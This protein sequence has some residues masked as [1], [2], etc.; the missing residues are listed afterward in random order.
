MLTLEYNVEAIHGTKR[1]HSFRARYAK[2]MQRCVILLVG[3]AA[4]GCASEKPVVSFTQQ[5]KDLGSVLEQTST[6]FYLELA[7]C[8][9]GDV[10]V[11]RLITTC[12]CTTSQSE[13]PFLLKAGASKKLEA[14]FDA[15]KVSGFKDVGILAEYSAKQEP[16][17]IDVL[18]FIARATV[19]AEI[20]AEVLVAPLSIIFPMVVQDPMS[21][22]VNLRFPAGSEYRVIDAAVSNPAFQARVVD[23]ATSDDSVTILVGV[24][25]ELAHGQGDA[26]SDKVK[27]TLTGG[28]LQELQIP[29]RA[30]FPSGVKLTPDAIVARESSYDQPSECAITSGLPFYAELV[31]SALELQLLQLI[32]AQPTPTNAVV[33]GRIPANSELSGTVL[34]V[35]IFF[36]DVDLDSVILTLPITVIGSTAGSVSEEVENVTN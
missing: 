1:D 34:H 24:L 30:T 35:R 6:P 14:T 7:N 22:E 16:G 23:N 15:G 18:R 13:T 11:W 27:I 10:V 21:K 12:G 32:L 25:P 17:E 26:V 4:M 29:V 20:R 28:R 33:R 5:Y 19:R 31:E 9:K 36:E 2:Q 8:G 3:V